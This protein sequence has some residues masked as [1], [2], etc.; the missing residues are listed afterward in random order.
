MKNS[1]DKQFTFASLIRFAIPNIIMMV[2]LSLYTIV[3]GIFISRF[4]GTTALS[5][6]NMSYPLN[7]LEMAL[8]IMLATG[9]SAIIARRMGEGKEQLAKENFTLV[10]TISLAV[11][12][13]FCVL[14]IAF[15]TPILHVLG[16][17]EGQF[18]YCLTYTRIL[19]MFAPIYFLYTAFQTLFIT[20]GKPH[21]GLATTII[22]GLT[23]MGLDY[24]FIVTCDMG[25]AGAA[26]A[27]GIGYCIPAFTGLLY[28]SVNKK[29]TL[30]F[31]PFHWDGP[32]VKNTCL[33]GSSEMVTNLA[34][35]V[36]TFLFNYIFMKYYLEDG[37]AS[38]TIVLYFQFV[39][40]AI[41]FGFSMGVAP[42]ISFKYGRGDKKQLRS[43]I[44]NSLTFIMVCSVAAYVI[45]LFTIGPALGI[46]TDTGSNVYNITEAGFPIFA[47]SFLFNGI[48]IL[49]SA[50]FTALSNGMASAIIS[51]ARTFLFLAGSIILLPII[52][53]AAGIW[54]AVPV[55]E[56]AGLIV[57]VVL[58]VKNK[59]RYLGK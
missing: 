18:D 11:G 22:A 4:V 34:T 53:G 40:T 9:S 7:C 41:Y 56:L 44:R 42:V 38:I 16:V 37:V 1:L 28:F 2:F 13:V 46:F 55:A 12:I 25:I 36:T 51:F 26:L 50:V 24:F 27:T 14:S 17:S 23:N 59:E 52:F 29:G 39:Y 58:A 35:A 33:N 8:G 5:A 3:D 19:M 32:M 31:V 43:V 54:W 47:I 30:R 45:S 20:A 10:V 15:M 57:S 21:L 48:G 49:A 6:I